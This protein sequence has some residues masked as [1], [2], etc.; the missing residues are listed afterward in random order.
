MD[1]KAIENKLRQVP[2]FPEEGVNF[3]DITTALQDGET[4]RAIIDHMIEAVSD[5]EI[6]VVVGSESRGFIMGTPMAY[7]LGVGFVPVRKPGRLPA[8]T[9]SIDYDLEYGSNT[10]ELHKD[11]IKP[12]EKVLVVDD[13]LA[14][15]GTANASCKLVEELGGEVVATSFFIELEGLGGR[16]ALDG[17]RIEA[18]LNM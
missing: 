13:L 3:I 9:V 14:T 16:K 4:L 17:Y 6:D 10:L 1:L 7:A 18:L 2:G 15:G 8:E 11:A 12:G 5:L